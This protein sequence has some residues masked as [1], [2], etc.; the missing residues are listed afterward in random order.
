MPAQA[1]QSILHISADFPDPLQPNKTK[2]VST[3]LELTQDT[4]RHQVYSLNR[5]ARGGGISAVEFGAGWRAVAYE[6]FPRGIFLQRYLSRVAAWIL[7]DLEKRRL[8]VA[9]VHAHKLSTD[10][11]VGAEVAEALAVPLVVSSQG[12]SDL[13]IIGTKRDLRQ[14]WQRIWR[15]AALILP[16]APWTAARLTQLLGPRDKPTVYLPCPTLQDRILPPRITGPLIRTAFHLRDYRNKNAETLIRAVAI[17]AR[18]IPDIR[19]EIIGGGDPQAFATL[20]RIVAR[21]GDGRAGLVGPVAHGSMQEVLNDS[22]A[23]VMA[24]FRESYGMVYAESLLAGTPVVHSA[25]NGISGY[26]DS[27]AVVGVD[28]RDPEALAEAVLRLVAGQDQIK[29]ELRDL[30]ERGGLDFLRRDAI[31]Q[32]YSRAV[33]SLSPATEQANSQDDGT[34]SVPQNG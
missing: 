12:N 23:F 29:A 34:D 14:T 2:A 16:F 17:A 27:P 15:D 7:K 4:F 6:G 1:D 31:A 9:F 10:A 19:L 11:L 22:C 8:D 26:L 25:T 3:L 32:V 18:R 21:E 13:K 5:V 24:S 28:P 33:A 20:N 30:Q